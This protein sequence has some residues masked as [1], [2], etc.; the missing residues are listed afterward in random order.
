MP[1]I[2]RGTPPG[3]NAIDNFSTDM[4]PTDDWHVSKRKSTDFG[5]LA[6][7]ADLKFG[8]PRLIHVINASNFSGN[9]TFCGHL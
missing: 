8:V 5:T 3:E 7:I 2:S 1:S 6:T 9:A 4:T